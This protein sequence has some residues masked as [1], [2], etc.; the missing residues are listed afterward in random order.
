MSKFFSKEINIGSNLDAEA[1]KEHKF[2]LILNSVLFILAA[3]VFWEFIYE[4]CHIIGSSV[5]GSVD[6]ALELILRM[7]PVMITAFTLVYMCAFTFNA[8]NSVASAIRYKNWKR[9]GI[10]VIV[11]GAVVVIYIIVGLIRG[12]YKKIIDGSFYPLYPLDFL[13]GGL[14][15]IAFGLWCIKYSDKLKKDGSKLPD[16]SRIK[17]PFLRGV[18]GF[19]CSLSFMVGLSSLAACFYGICT[20]DW[21]HGY[22]FFN[23][24]IWLNYFVAF[25]QVLDFRFLYAETKR[26][27]R[28][29]MLVKLGVMFL[30][31]NVVLLG[32]YLLSVQLQNEAP[33]QNAYS[34][35]PIDLA[36]NFNAFL[37]IIGANNIL[38]PIVAILKGLVTSKKKA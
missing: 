25:A 4:L 26:E 22:L 28:P 6:Q 27:E 20:M 23:V 10:T 1:K 19:F 33:N 32:L 5:S 14:V 12:Q 21:T 37:V 18:N 24:M 2:Y 31:L 34:I 13:I 29:G 3:F 15:L 38:A 8:Y 30:V 35:L 17:N 7:L 11:W 16:G 9:G 36:A